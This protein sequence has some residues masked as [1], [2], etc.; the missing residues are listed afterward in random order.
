MIPVI[1]VIGRNSNVGKTTVVCEVVSLLKTMGLRIATIK[2]DSKGFDID[3]PGKDTWKHAQA[4]SDIV[5]ISSPKKY[6]YI[7][8]RQEEYTI[9][10]IISKIKDVDIIITEGFK[11]EDKP[12]IEVFR[13]GISKEP[14]EL[15]SN[16]FAIVTDTQ[17]DYNIPQFQFN[18]IE[19]LVGLIVKEFKIDNKKGGI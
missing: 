1:S 7:E 14:L 13:K 16:T 2:H 19:D 6:A 10:E 11:N 18:E 17:L 5:I 15:G 4:G 12:K 8:K 3:H 9:D